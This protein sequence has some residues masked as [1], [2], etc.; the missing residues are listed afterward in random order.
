MILQQKKINKVIMF[1]KC[2]LKDECLIF[3]THD[4][5]D[6]Y[7]IRRKEKEKLLSIIFKYF[8]RNL[9]HILFKIS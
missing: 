7:E 5:N 8:N 9:I 2:I 4:S 6:I 1:V 3:Q